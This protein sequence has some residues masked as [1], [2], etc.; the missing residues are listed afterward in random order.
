[1]NNNYMYDAFISYRHSDLDQFVAEN[2]HKQMETFKL[3]KSLIKKNIASRTKIERVFRDK[4]ELLEEEKSLLLLNDDVNTF[5]YVI[6]T[7]VEVCEHT[8]EQAETCALITHYKG[9]CTVKS[10]T[11]EELEP[12][13]VSL[14]NHHLYA[15]I[16]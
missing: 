3:P 5:D 12:Y 14:L 7:L 6:E 15:K 16:Q 13:Y 9:K 11:Y 4:E 2:L 10:G 8:Y 1:M